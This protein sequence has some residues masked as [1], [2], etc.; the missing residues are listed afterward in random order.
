MALLALILAVPEGAAGSD[1]WEFWHAQ[2]H[3]DIRAGI[4]QFGRGNLPSYILDPLVAWGRD[5]WAAAHQQ[6]HNDANG[7]L[8]LRG[9]DLLDVDWQSS[10]EKDEWLFMNFM[11]HAAMHQAIGI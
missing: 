4:E 5:A 2:D 8:G 3:I 10:A 6:A 11:E 9:S 1:E 7:A